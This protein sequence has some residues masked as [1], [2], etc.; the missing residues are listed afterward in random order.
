[1]GKEISTV[2]YFDMTLL[3]PASP[4]VLGSQ[5][6]LGK[7]GG[8]VALVGTPTWLLYK[9]KESKIGSACEILLFV[10]RGQNADPL[11]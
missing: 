7:V 4:W 2:I 1:M 3:K 11:I 10:P 9:V 6:I 5:S 8:I